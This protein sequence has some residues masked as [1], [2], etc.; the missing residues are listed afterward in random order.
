MWGDILLDGGIGA[1]IDHDKGTDYSY[2]DN[3]PV[4]MGKSITID[5]AQQNEVSQKPTV[6][7]KSPAQK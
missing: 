7:A 6:E 3:L 5:R 1:I 4:V 2:P